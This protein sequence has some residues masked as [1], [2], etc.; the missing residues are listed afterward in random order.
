MKPVSP[1]LRIS[2]GLVLLTIS[3][4]L[5]AELL[6]LAPDPARATLD[7]RKKVCESLAVQWSVAAT[8]GDIDAIR[9]TVHS[10]V[11]RNDDILSASLRTLEDDKPLAVA[12]EHERYWERNADEQISTPTQAVV[13]IFRGEERWGSV[14]VRFEPLYPTTW[15][16]IE[17]RPLTKLIGFVAL[18]AFGGFLIFMRR[19][20]R[21]LDPAAL[22]PARVKFALDALAEGV[23]LMDRQG[24][25]MLANKAYLRN[26][27]RDEEAVQGTRISEWQ[28][29][30]ADNGQIAQDVP[31]MRALREGRRQTGVSLV[32]E[33]A[34]GGSRTF[35]INASLIEGRAG[36]VRGVFA[37]FN[38]VTELENKN[39]KLEKAL[40]QLQ[41]SRNELQLK[42]QQLEVLA[43]R[44]PLT[45]CLNRR[46][47]F[48]RIDRAIARAQR[49]NT[50]VACIMADIDHFKKVNDTWGHATGDE[51]IKHFANLLSSDLRKADAIGRYGGEEF[52]LLLW[53]SNM[54]Q[55]LGTAERLR[56]AVEAST[57]ELP[58]TGSFG[59]A[60]L[61]A[62]VTDS[63]M[64]ID[65][66]D[67]ALYAAKQGGRNRVE[68]VL[69]EH[70][71]HVELALS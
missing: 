15:F 11:E 10:L 53:D 44:D 66:A 45:G 34:A 6:G 64:L 13:P 28:W 35:I 16:G 17:L 3:F 37:T 47:F 51:V 70:E 41:R 1:A 49:S 71:G 31:W 14:E 25:V 55:A 22:V 38:D 32:L 24:R 42:N 4:L 21:H 46:A 43:T 39:T 48:E 56:A 8:H 54:E 33:D 57:A 27:G 12:G 61:D 69:N 23:V 65:R 58:V 68:Y 30:R 59:V 60:C 2:V 5:V 40:D 52:C 7:A 62:G 36:E 50:P 26:S 18:A 20:L 19:T 67:K 9:E 63:A 29:L